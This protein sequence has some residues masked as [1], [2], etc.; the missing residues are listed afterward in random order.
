MIS[1]S[2]NLY[3]FVLYEMKK[4]VSWN[5]CIGREGKAL[6]NVSIFKRETTFIIH[7]DSELNENYEIGIISTKSGSI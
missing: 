6:L 1:V 5:Y 2:S 3:F 4:V 7:G